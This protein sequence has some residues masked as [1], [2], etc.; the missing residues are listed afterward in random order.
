MRERGLQEVNSRDSQDINLQNL[1]EI[2]PQDLLEIQR[3][4]AE[5]TEII[6]SLRQQLRDNEDLVSYYESLDAGEEKNRRKSS[7]TNNKSCHLEIENTHD[8][9][10]EIQQATSKFLSLIIRFLQT[11]YYIVRGKEIFVYLDS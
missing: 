11:G 7:P 1:R 6:A 8:L 9:S 3:K 2:D 10:F 4:Y 5:Q